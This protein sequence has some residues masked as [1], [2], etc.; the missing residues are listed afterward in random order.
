VQG[1]GSRR[2]RHYAALVCLGSLQTLA[3][4]RRVFFSSMA[5][6]RDKA[7]IVPRK[8]DGWSRPKAVVGMFC[9]ERLLS[10]PETADAEPIIWK[11]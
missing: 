4:A 2:S 10:A 6:L 3:V 7:D 11:I 1:P 8:S 5:A 9:I